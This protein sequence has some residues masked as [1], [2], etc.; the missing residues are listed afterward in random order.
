M[1]VRSTIKTGKVFEYEF[2]DLP[3]VSR[4]ALIQYGAQRWI[5]DRVNSTTKSKEITEAKDID[6]LG[7]DILARL[8]SGVI[9]RT[10]GGATRDP[11]I[12]MQV[13]IV[14]EI[15][16]EAKSIT[17]KVSAKAIRTHGLDKF[18]DKLGVKK[19]ETMA[20]ER[21][22]ASANVE[23]ADFDIEALL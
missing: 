6:K 7:E 12:E 14:Q 22:E 23:V 2:D 13:R 15:L 19:I 9:G 17:F 4:N 20:K 8:Q 3:E 18:K 21:L 16:K 10:G 5:N 11:F 1:E